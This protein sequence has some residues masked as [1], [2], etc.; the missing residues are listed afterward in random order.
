MDKIGYLYETPQ[1]IQIADTSQILCKKGC[2]Y[3]KK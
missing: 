2:Q 3:Y 1:P